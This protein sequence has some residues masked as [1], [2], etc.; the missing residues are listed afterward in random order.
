[1]GDS[2]KDLYHEALRQH[3][4][5]PD[6]KALAL[7]AAECSGSETLKAQLRRHEDLPVYDVCAELDRF[8]VRPST[9]GLR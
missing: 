9:P 6:L 1:M 5:L 2:W 3:H 8:N 7:H 4:P